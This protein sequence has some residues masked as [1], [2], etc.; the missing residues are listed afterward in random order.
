MGVML[1][2]DQK[3]FIEY[4]NL[5]TCDFPSKNQFITA[6]YK[7]ET[8]LFDLVKTKTV[9]IGFGLSPGGRYFSIMGRDKILRLFDFASG[10]I[11]WRIDETNEHLREI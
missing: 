6:K 2:V 5:E 10:K 3:G 1:S 8:D 9:V 7:I 11:I 4:W